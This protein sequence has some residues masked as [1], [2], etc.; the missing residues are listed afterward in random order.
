MEAP[1][2]PGRT[3]VIRPRAPIS[4]MR[5]ETGV[6]LQR[7]AARWPPP[8]PKAESVPGPA[9]CVFCQN[10]EVREILPDA[11]TTSK[12]RGVTSA[13]FSACNF[14]GGKSPGSGSCRIGTPTRHALVAFRRSLARA[15]ASCGEDAGRS[16][17]REEGRGRRDCRRRDRRVPP[18]V[19]SAAS[20]AH[21]PV[22]PFPSPYSLPP[23]KPGS[24]H[25]RTRPR[26]RDPSRVFPQVPARRLSRWRGGR[27]RRS[28]ADIHA[29]CG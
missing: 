5:C 4:G 19:G 20:S 13:R 3:L 23:L 25:R 12:A 2:C 15:N 22:S 18:G 24:E 29:R 26:C 10:D 14:S 17:A 8:L 7:A 1:E 6:S 11:Y 28:A 27:L 21:A 16:P 9:G